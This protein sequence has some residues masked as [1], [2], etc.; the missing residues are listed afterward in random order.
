L[1]VCVCAGLINHACA[2]FCAGVD[3]GF[4]G[5]S[6]FPHTVSLKINSLSR[7]VWWCACCCCCCCVI[8]SLFFKNGERAHNNNNNTHTAKNTN[9]ALK[10][11]FLFWLVFFGLCGGCFNDPS[12]KIPRPEKGSLLFQCQPFFV[13]TKSKCHNQREIFISFLVAARGPVPCGKRLMALRC[14]RLASWRQSFVQLGL[15]LHMFAP[16]SWYSTP[17]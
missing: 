16:F 13:C 7:N 14:P 17:E 3:M 5:V 4:V 12:P 10:K 11:R 2:F 6:I 8:V 15:S 1:F 9:Y